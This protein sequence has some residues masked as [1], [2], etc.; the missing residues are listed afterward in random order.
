MQSSHSMILDMVNNFTFFLIMQLQIWLMTYAVASG[1]YPPTYIFINIRI[2][3]QLNTVHSLPPK[4]LIFQL[5][6][7]PAMEKKT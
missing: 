5:Q 7:T 6:P 1:E 4:Q 2:R 3:C